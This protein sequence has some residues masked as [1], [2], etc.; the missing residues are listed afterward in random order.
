MLKSSAKRATTRRDGTSGAF[1]VCP[2]SAPRS[3]CARRGAYNHHTAKPTLPQAMNI[4]R[5]AVTASMPSRAETHAGT[6]AARA[7]KAAASEPTM[8]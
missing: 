2:G 5:M 1:P 3:G 8:V 4:A 7:L 6:P